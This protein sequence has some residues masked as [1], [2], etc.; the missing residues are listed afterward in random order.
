MLLDSYVEFLFFLPLLLSGC[1]HLALIYSLEKEMQ[2][3]LV[4]LE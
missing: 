2:R 3:Q 4:V 1:I